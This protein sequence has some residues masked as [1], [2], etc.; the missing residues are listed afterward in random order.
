MFDSTSVVWCPKGGGANRALL[1]MVSN[2]TAGATY[3]FNEKYS[4]IIR[5]S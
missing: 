1:S 3:Y 2:F 4:F 5:Q